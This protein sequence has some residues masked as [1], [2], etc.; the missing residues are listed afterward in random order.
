MYLSFCN[1][2][3]FNL[4]FSKLLKI[5]CNSCFSNRVSF[6]AVDGPLPDPM[7]RAGVPNQMMSRMP[8]QSGKE[9]NK[10]FVK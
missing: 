2:I 5:L 4:S 6:P 7:I 9:T 3:V 1:F 10:K 8:P